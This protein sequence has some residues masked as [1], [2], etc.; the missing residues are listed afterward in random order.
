MPSRPL[1]LGTLLLKGVLQKV[2]E[3]AITDPGIGWDT[4]LNEI[5]EREARIEVGIDGAT[6][7]TIFERLA[8]KARASADGMGLFSQDDIFNVFVE[9]CEYPP[10]EQALILLL[11]LPGLGIDSQAEGTRK[12]IDAD[13]VDTCRAGDVTRFVR[14]PF[15]FELNFRRSIHSLQDWPFGCVIEMKIYTK[16]FILYRAA[17]KR[18]R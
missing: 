17:T 13:L 7:R 8:T 5:S 12:V 10:D 14:D 18:K 4:L 1:L 3:Q 9:V 6:V 2:Q 11:R 16:Q 15:A